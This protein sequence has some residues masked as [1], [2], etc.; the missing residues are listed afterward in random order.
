M[1]SKLSVLMLKGKSV[2][3]MSDMNKM[4]VHLE[5][6]LAEKDGLD[7]KIRQGLTD[8][9]IKAAQF[10]IFCGVDAGTLSE[11]FKA[12][13]VV[14]SMEGDKDGPT[15]FLYEEPGQSV[16]EH[17]NYIIRN[18]VDLRRI[19]PKIY[20]KVVDCWSYRD[21]IGTIDIAIKRL[22]ISSDTAS[23]PVATKP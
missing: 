13:A 17:L 3:E 1:Q 18:G 10:I 8:P 23:S 12:V 6:L 7:F 9:A 4:S 20:N 14:D 5:Q 19:N 21:I 15:I 2:D 22:G 16:W 11:F